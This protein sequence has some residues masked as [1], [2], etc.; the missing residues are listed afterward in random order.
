VEEEGGCQKHQTDLCVVVVVEVVLLLLRGVRC[1]AVRCGAM[2]AMACLG[3]P[4]LPVPSLSRPFRP[5][6][7]LPRSIITTSSNVTSCALGSQVYHSLSL[8][9]FI[10][11]L[12]VVVAAAIFRPSHSVSN[13]L[14]RFLSRSQAGIFPASILA[15][16]A[17]KPLA[18]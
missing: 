1:G 15:A 2:A 8:I 12:P 18:N 17:T 4:A 7:S 10:S 5:R 13:F 14:L 11:S 6:S 3:C 16:G 9:P